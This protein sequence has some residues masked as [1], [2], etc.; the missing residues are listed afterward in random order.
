MEEERSGSVLSFLYHNP[1]GRVVLR[2]L[3]NPVISKVAGAFLSTRCSKFLIR[4]YVRNY[5]IDLSAYEPK[6][7]CSFNDFFT[8][9]IRMEHRP[10]V[11]TGETLVSP[12]DGKLS[13]Y[14][15]TSNSVFPVKGRS[16]TVRE[17]LRDAELAE[18]F[19]DGFCF[20]FRLT[21]DDYHRYFYF[22]D[23]RKSVNVFLKG[24]LHTVRPIALEKETVFC[25][26]SREYTVIDTDH[27][28]KAVQMEVGALMVGRICN[29][30]QVKQ[31]RRGEEKGLFE[32]GG[33][34]IILLLQKGAVEPD[35]E[36]LS[37]T[38]HGWETEVRCGEPIGC[39][40]AKK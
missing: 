21:V 10:F 7:Y 16:Y 29:Y 24:R 31:I 1:I 15:I 13:V 2:L 20:V 25:E 19:Q 36:L 9:K 5:Q 38:T 32:F 22:D 23:G 37:N 28:G 26:N 17:L 18:Q 11:M 4:P 6:R 40:A 27:F 30:H 12:C 34:T 14:R 39:Q 35:K 3:T 8:R 33:S